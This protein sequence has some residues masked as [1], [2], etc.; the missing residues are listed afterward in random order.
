MNMSTMSKILNNSLKGTTAF[1]SACH[2][3]TDHAASSEH[4][5]SFE[6]FFEETTFYHG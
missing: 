6:D 2:D 1:Q 3:Y 5:L 4:P